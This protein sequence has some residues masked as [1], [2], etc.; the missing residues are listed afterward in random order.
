MALAERIYKEKLDK[1]WV[2]LIMAARAMGL[3]RDVI[4]DVLGSLPKSDN[5]SL[6]LDEKTFIPDGHA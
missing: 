2:D 4:R 1:E 5:G 6:H 3:E